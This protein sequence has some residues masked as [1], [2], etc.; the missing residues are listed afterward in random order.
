MTKQ[1]N[2]DYFWDVLYEQMGERV[3]KYINEHRDVTNVTYPKNAP[4]S[5]YMKIDADL[6]N[7]R[8]YRDQVSFSAYPDDYTDNLD[9]VAVEGRIQFQSKHQ[10]F[11]GGM[12]EEVREDYKSEVLT[13]PT[14]MEVCLCANDMINCTGDNHHIFLEAIHK[15]G[16]FTLDDK[17]FVL[18]YDFSMGS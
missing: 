4:L 8:V 12:A 16:Q 10:A 7:G 13:N 9:E 11:F 1:S 3:S 18:I 14:W 17:S 2:E 5:E 6:Q 15:T